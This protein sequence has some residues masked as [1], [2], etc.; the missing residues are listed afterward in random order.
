MTLLCP[1]SPQM[2]LRL[3]YEKR[4]GASSKF[5]DY[6]SVLPD[7][8]TTLLSFS[9][10]EIPELQVKH[11]AARP[12]EL[13]W[14]LPANRN[15]ACAFSPKMP[16]NKPRLCSSLSHTSPALTRERSGSRSSRRPRTINCFTATYGTS[17]WLLC[18]FPSPKR[19]SHGGSAVQGLAP[20][21]QI[22]ARGRTGRSCVP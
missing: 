20:L 21:L 6:I 11:T 15:H 3:V 12:S 1:S 22:L 7:A 4:L 18:K 10:S 9:E 16:R 2:A 13:A 8:F 5:A 17:W 19:S 14:E